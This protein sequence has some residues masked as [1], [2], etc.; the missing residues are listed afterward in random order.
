MVEM[1]SWLL[2]SVWSNYANGPCKEKHVMLVYK[3]THQLQNI[4]RSTTYENACACQ[5]QSNQP[6]LTSK[7]LNY[8]VLL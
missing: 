2:T 7:H 3:K 8:F 6:F 1:M 5:H 4:Q